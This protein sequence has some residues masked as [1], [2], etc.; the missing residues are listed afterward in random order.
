MNEPT[1][2]DPPAPHAR[3]D[4]LLLI[5]ALAL[6]LL[7]LCAA[8][9]LFRRNAQQQAAAS[10]S[11]SPS[12]AAATAENPGAPLLTA[13]FLDVGQ[14]DAALLLS[15]GGKT[16][17]VDAGPSGSF[18]AVRRLLDSLGV[19]SLDM[20]VC[21]HL[22][23]DHIGG[24]AEVVRRYPVGQLYLPPFDIENSAYADLVAALD[25]EGVTATP[26][27]AAAN[28]TLVWDDG[29]EVRVLSPFDVTYD[30]ENDTS[31]VLRIAYGNTSLLLCGDAG[32]TSELLMKKAFPDRYLHADVLKVGH[33]GSNTGTKRKFLSAVRPKLAVIS[34]GKDNGYGLPDEKVLARLTDAGARILRTDE[35]GT[36]EIQLDGTSA[37]VVE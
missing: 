28:E 6:S 24:M 36:V 25:E 31:V 7:L 4:R 3:R 11:P 23:S 32:E 10:P 29:V 18:P 9:L 15:P 35:C 22:H 37:W 8:F 19:R 27:H 17:L 2:S 16:M 1:F 26:V 13:Y 5:S 14:G 20:V 21:T 34:V 30:D 12:P 33:H